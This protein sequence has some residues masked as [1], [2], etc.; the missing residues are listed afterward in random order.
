MAIS[1]NPLECFGKA[2]ILGDVFNA[3]GTD[4]NF[5]AAGKQSSHETNHINNND[6][7]ETESYNFNPGARSLKARIITLIDHNRPSIA[8]D[9]LQSKMANAPEEVEAIAQD[10]LYELEEAGFDQD[11]KEFRTM[12]SSA[13]IDTPKPKATEDLVAS[14]L[15]FG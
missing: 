6:T 10:V 5:S 7:S 15:V 4:K 9:I 1:V 13:N 14:S 12:L 3:L 8:L 2:P 11:A